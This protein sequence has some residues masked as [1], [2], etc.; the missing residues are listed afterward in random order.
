MAAAVQAAE[1]DRS[2]TW[3]GRSTEDAE[4]S[5]DRCC[6]MH[7]D[8]VLILDCWPMAPSPPSEIYAACVLHSEVFELCSGHVRERLEVLNEGFKLTRFPL[9]LPFQHVP[10]KRAHSMKN[11][12]RCQEGSGMVWHALMSHKALSIMV[13]H[14][15][16]S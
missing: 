9:R 15:T 2:E 14:S 13:P 4:V 10:W 5:R 11:I 6:Q 16:L 1:A 12:H 8:G 7:D 3:S